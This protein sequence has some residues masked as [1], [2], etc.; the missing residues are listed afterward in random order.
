MSKICLVTGVGPGTG[1]AI[2]RRFADA[3]YDVAM[4]ARNSDR[5]TALAAEL[6]TAHSWPCDVSNRE[7]LQH[8]F[9]QI[10][11]RHGAPTII[12][13]N[14]VAAKPG[15]YM[16]VDPARM[17]LAFEVNTIALLQLAQLATPAMVE[18]GSGAI[19]CTGN[20]AAY[21]GR[22][23]FAGFAPTKAAQRILLESIAREAGPQG[24]HA[25]YIAIDAVIDVPWTRK[26]YADKPDEFFC[27]P[28]DIAEECYRLAHQ[29]RSAWTFESVIRPFG[30]VW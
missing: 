6:P 12:V 7:L 29:P 3:G 21:R 23:H 30:E 16:D 4:L 11:E 25:A 5:L 19:L 8:T 27:Q 2:V 18:A 9:E 28:A 20:T 15:T 24:I 26:A 1:A 17:R 13:H 14:A 10:T 22:P